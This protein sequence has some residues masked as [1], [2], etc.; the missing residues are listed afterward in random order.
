LVEER[1]AE[2]LFIAARMTHQLR[3][4]DDNFQEHDDADNLHRG[5]DRTPNKLDRGGHRVGVGARVPGRRAP[6]PGR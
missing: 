4:S 5:D 1:P 2:E 6:S 3:A